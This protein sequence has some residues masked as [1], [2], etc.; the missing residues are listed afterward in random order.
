M[1]YKKERLQRELNNLI[2]E[3][4]QSVFYYN[5]YEGYTTYSQLS[6]KVVQLPLAGMRLLTKTNNHYKVSEMDYSP[7]YSLGGVSFFKEDN[8]KIPE[9]IPEQTSTMFWA[10]YKNKKIVNLEIIENH[11]QLN[12]KKITI[13]FGIVITFEDLLKCYI[14]NVSIEGFNDS[15]G[16]YQIIRGQEL[17]LFNDNSISD[18]KFLLEDINF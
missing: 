6:D 3:E 13:P 7:Y 18:Y 15:K 12:A 9:G 11:H 1:E 17:V 2:G 10:S 4:I 14:F 5:E 8:A 16:V